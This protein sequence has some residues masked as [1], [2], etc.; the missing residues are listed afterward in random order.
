MTDCILLF[1]DLDTDLGDLIAIRNILDGYVRHR[2]ITE[3]PS[4]IIDEMSMR[5]I[6]ALIVGLAIDA[7]EPAKD[8]LFCHRLDIAVHSGPS[9]F[10]LL[11][12][13][14]IK[15]IIRREVSASTGCTDDITILVGSHIPLIMIINLKKAT[16]LLKA[17]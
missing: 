4:R 13:D 12:P 9:D 10:W 15:N 16:F 14:L 6:I 3:H 5:R 17:T 8:S 11:D 1:A 2:E 7:R